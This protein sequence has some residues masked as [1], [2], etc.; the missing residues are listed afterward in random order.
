VLAALA[1]PETPSLEGDTVRELATEQLAHL[2][3]SDDLKPEQIADLI[4]ALTKPN[5]S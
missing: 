3:K 5:K 4:S 2:M 1:L